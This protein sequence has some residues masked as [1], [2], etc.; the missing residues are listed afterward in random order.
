MKR[1]EFER[2][3][4]QLLNLLKKIL[5]QGAQ[6]G[7]S[8]SPLGFLDKIPS[9]KIILN[10]CL[11]NFLPITDDEMAELEEA[12]AEGMERQHSHDTE[13]AAD[14]FNWNDSD[15]DFLKRNGMTF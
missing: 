1:D 3:V 7:S 12:Y 9:E 10:L 8:S 6:G 11:F 2:N 15:I 4:F 14:E 5:K 13:D